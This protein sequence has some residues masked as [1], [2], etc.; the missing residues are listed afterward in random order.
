MKKLF[1][2]FLYRF[3]FDY[4]LSPLNCYGYQP[5]LILL[6]VPATKL[7]TIIRLYTIIINGYYELLNRAT[8][9]I[10]KTLFQTL[11]HLFETIFGI[12]H[13]KSLLCS[14]VLEM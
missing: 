9:N 4:V 1:L 3:K 12:V 13:V 11:L 7:R 8:G 14:I 5:S 2:L 10:V 6:F